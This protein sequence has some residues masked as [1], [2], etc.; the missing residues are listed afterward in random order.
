MMYD[1]TELMAQSAVDDLTN[2]R[3]LDIT[4]Q[5]RSAQRESLWL[6]RAY[7]AGAA[8]V[9]SVALAVACCAAKAEG[10]HPDANRTNVQ[11]EMHWGSRTQ[12]IT[13]CSQ[14]GAW[15]PGVT[16]HIHSIA[17]CN[18]FDTQTGICH[19]YAVMPEAL[20]DEATTQLGHEVAHCLLGRYHS[21][22]VL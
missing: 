9:V 19:I 1:G 16:P 22:D 7:T 13:R 14:L 5:V 2:V 4:A 11:I 6:C 10:I 17:D 18:A 15:G 3:A 8:I 20:N 12:T 21:Q